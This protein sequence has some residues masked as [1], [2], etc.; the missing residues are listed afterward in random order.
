MKR[1]PTFFSLVVLVGVALVSTACAAGE[2]PDSVTVDAPLTPSAPGPPDVSAA[3]EP[4]ENA[5]APS[6][7]VTLYVSNQSF[8]DPSVGITITIDGAVVADQ[9]FDV[10]G[11]HNWIEFD[12]DLTAGDHR[13]I[14]MSDT[15]TELVVDFS[16][17]LDLP[18]WAVISY[19]W[20]AEEG[21]ANFTFDISDEPL[22]FA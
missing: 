11:Q 21:A 20:Y 9:D 3:P 10:E 15:G 17:E 22:G 6:S 12:L 8:D 7:P 14:A 4:D 13:L 1:Q 19:W 18:R 5:E 16:T 2:S